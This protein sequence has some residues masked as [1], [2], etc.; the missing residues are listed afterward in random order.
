MKQESK[1]IEI[2]L[3]PPT[4]MKAHRLGPGPFCFGHLDLGC[5]K[6]SCYLVFSHGF[7]TKIPYSL[8]FNIGV[9]RELARG[10]V[11]S[12]DYVRNHGIGLP[13]LYADYERRRD[14]ATLNV[15]AAR[16]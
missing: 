12:V 10:T 6:S 8:Q 7:V 2:S 4:A 5:H 3:T 14:A 9:Q 1:G 16:T 13:M 11:L 15:A